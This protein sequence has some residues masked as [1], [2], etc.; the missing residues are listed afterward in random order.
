M[1]REMHY[2]LAGAAARL[3]HVARFA[4]EMLLQHGPDRLVVAMEC[5]RIEAPVRPG[6]VAAKFDRMLSHAGLSLQ[7]A[8][9]DFSNA[10]FSMG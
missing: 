2:V 10:L 1:A 3:Q 6:P 5:R 9:I 8:A 4:G 7:F